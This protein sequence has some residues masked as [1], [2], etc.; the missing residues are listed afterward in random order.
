MTLEE[1]LKSL[2]EFTDAMFR[3]HAEEFERHKQLIQELD[4]RITRRIDALSEAA[5]RRLDAQ[6]QDLQRHDQALVKIDARLDRIAE[7]V[8]RF[9]Q[10]QARDGHQGE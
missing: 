5:A 1:R 9:I 8:E 10:G 3:R 7:L 4:Q 6:D 2:A